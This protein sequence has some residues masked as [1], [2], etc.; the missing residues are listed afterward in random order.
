[1]DL[2]KYLKYLNKDLARLLKERENLQKGVIKKDIEIEK[3]KEKIRKI[4]EM[5]A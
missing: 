4:Q 2:E 3:A 1:M 5:K